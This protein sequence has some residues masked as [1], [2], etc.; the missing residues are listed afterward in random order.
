MWQTKISVLEMWEIALFV[1]TD[2]FKKQKLRLEINIFR[3]KRSK[4]VEKLTSPTNNF[5]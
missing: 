3:H 1:E 4:K 2:N 5:H